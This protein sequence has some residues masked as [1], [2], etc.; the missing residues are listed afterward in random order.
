MMARLLLTVVYKLCYEPQKFH[1][2]F[3]RKLFAF[4]S[5]AFDYSMLSR[6]EFFQKTV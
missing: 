2:S 1:K 6:I 3:N 5:H 4:N